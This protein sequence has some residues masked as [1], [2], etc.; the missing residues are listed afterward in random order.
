MV[1]GGL[2]NTDPEVDSPISSLIIRVLFMRRKSG[3]WLKLCSVSLSL[4]IPSRMTR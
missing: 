3:G 1:R 4:R 2:G